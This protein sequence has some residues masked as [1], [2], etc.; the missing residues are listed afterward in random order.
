MELDRHLL[1]PVKNSR[2]LGAIFA[3]IAISTVTPVF[4]FP[5]SWSPFNFNFNTQQFIQNLW[6]RLCVN[7]YINNNNPYCGRV[8]T[9]P[10]PISIPPVISTSTSNQ[11]VK[12]FCT[13]CPIGQYSNIEQCINNICTSCVNGVW[14]TSTIPNGQ[15]IIIQGQNAANG[16]NSANGA[17]GANGL[18]G[19][20]NNGPAGYT[21]GPGR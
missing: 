4:A 10:P 14:S 11:C 13:T 7:P 8:T 5:F 18:P 1:A 20:N 15:P 12:N 2:I 9:I 3:I 16:V 17:N 21:Y 19:T 6:Q